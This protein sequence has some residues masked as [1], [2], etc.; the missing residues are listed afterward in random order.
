MSKTLFFICLTLYILEKNSAKANDGFSKTVHNL[1]ELMQFINTSNAFS[2]NKI[3]CAAHCHIL[4]CS[5]WKFEKDTNQCH[6]GYLEKF[7]SNI[8]PT[9]TVENEPMHHFYVSMGFKFG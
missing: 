1:N 7:E 3:Q 6:M 8:V 5:L 9:S 2:T 4:S